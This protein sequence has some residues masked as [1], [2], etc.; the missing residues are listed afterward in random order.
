MRIFLLKSVLIFVIST[1]SL[2]AAEKPSSDRLRFENDQLVV[3]VS[4]RSP[5]QIAA[6]YEGRK[7]PPSMIERLK[8]ACFI[9]VG[10]HN[11]SG[12]VLWHNLK[13]WRFTSGNQPVKRY[14]RN[15]WKSEWD[16]LQ[17]PMASQSTFRWT[18][19]PEVLDFRAGEREGGNII[20]QRTDKA[21]DIHAR[22]I[23]GRNKDGKMIDVVLENITCGRDAK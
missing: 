5:D 2:F 16:S 13:R 14:H 1:T 23:L 20:L 6:F 12:K 11:K 10:I 4:P 22:F 15:E 19:L 18:L 7:F 17:V 9:T 21:F 8:K 3:R